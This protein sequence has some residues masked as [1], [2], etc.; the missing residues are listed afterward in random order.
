MKLLTQEILNRLPPLYAQDGKG[1]DAIAH[2]KFFTPDAQWTWYATE[3]DPQDRIFFGY[4]Q[5]IEDEFG[6]F[7]LDELQ[8]VRG[9]L[10]LPV[11]RDFYFKPTPLRAIVEKNAP[12]EVP[13]SISMP[14][15]N[16][17]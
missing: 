5:G 8:E 17:L 6:Y 14:V 12:V 15:C 13:Q 2:V 7:S 1:L 16:P 4:V 3:Y 10:A 11:E 9:V